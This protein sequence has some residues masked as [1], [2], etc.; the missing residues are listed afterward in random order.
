MLLKRSFRQILLVV[1]I[2][3]L[4]PFASVEGDMK[5]EL[6]NGMV[7]EVP[8]NKDDIVSITFGDKARSTAVGETLTIPN[9]KPVKVASTSVL[10]AGRWYVLEASG[11]V[12]DWGHVKDGVDP[13][14]CYAEWRCGKQGEA[15]QQLR[16]DGKGMNDIAGKVIS[17][18]PQHTYQVRYQGRGKTL[19][20]YASD[21]QESWQ[22]NSGA[23]TL[24]I[25]PE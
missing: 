24:K 14:W 25:I 1:G 20:V 8:V 4:I 16:I 21:A 6:K 11:V 9:D 15:W 17:Y 23:F 22:D 7:I 19:E 18:S 3:V 13:V 5:V 10:E 12:S 2:A